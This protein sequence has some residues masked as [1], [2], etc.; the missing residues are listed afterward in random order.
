MG[1]MGRTKLL[2][3][4]HYQYTTERTIAERRMTNSQLASEMPL[5]FPELG[6][7]SRYT[8]ARCRHELSFRYLPPLTEISMSASARNARVRWCQYQQEIERDWTKV[9]F[10]DESWFEIGANVRKL[11]RRPHE[12]GPDVCSPHTQHPVKVLVWGAIGH[13]FKS[14]LHIVPANVTID[15]TYYFEDIVLGGFIDQADAAYPHYDWILQQDNARP[16]VRREVLDSLACLE[17][18]VLLDWPL[19]SPD[20]NIILR[21]LAIMKGMVAFRDPKNRQEPCDVIEQ[22]WADLKMETINALVAEM[23]RRPITV[24]R[25][26]GGTIQ[27]V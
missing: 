20:L 10:T 21:V 17:V 22:V 14:E 11:W 4:D 6:S 9:V 1:H 25:R 8:I 12:D 3:V 19:Y 15:G 2:G 18:N 26:E 24:I 27:T 23:P 7:I 13:S 16:H 5:R